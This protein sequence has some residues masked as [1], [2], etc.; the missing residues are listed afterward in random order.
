MW[1]DAISA[2]VSSL[3]TGLFSQQ[4]TASLWCGSL[5]RGDLSDQGSERIKYLVVVTEGVQAMFTAG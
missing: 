3:I 4:A 5:E 2:L 1:E